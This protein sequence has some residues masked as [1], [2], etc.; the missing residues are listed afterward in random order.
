M[1]LL[2]GVN[3]GKRQLK[4]EDL[5]RIAGD[6]GLENPSTYI[7]SGNLLFASEKSETALKS[8]LEASLAAHMGA[9][10]GVMIRTAA[11]MAA[12]AAACPFDVPGN[13]A[14]AIFLDAPPPADAAEHAKNQANEEIALGGRE[15]YVHYP[16]G[17]GPSKLGLP[18][19]AKGTA[20]NMNTVA[21]LAELAMGKA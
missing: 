20:R 12:V 7:A 10:V 5:R 15:L 6:L 13:R 1:A 18:A 4:M 3:L 2:R 16:D 11:E 21:K 8:A 9:P 17:Q 19:A 14:V